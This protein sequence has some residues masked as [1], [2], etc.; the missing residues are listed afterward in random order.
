MHKFFLFAVV[1]LFARL[2]V[3]DTDEDQRWQALARADIEA[4]HDAIERAHPGAIDA[5]NPGFRVWMEDGYHE[6]LGLLPGVYDYDSMLDAARYYVTGFQDGHLIYSDNARGPLT[7][8]G[9]SLVTGWR[10]AP[11]DGE[12]VVTKVWEGFPSEVPPV[13]SRLIQCDGQDPGALYR[14][15]IAPFYDQRTV[16]GFSASSHEVGE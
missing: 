3:G 12:Y 15:R 9:P 7:H 16:A 10:V 1:L 5:L 2:A 13:G 11:M 4:V 8:N 14:E 6:A